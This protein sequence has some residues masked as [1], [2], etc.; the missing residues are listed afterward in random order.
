M[1]ANIEARD[2]QVWMLIGDNLSDQAKPVAFTDDAI[3]ALTRAS[4]T[5][6]RYARMQRE[7]PHYAIDIDPTEVLPQAEES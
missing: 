4:R 5:A 3:D 7:A 2:G 1:I 6:S